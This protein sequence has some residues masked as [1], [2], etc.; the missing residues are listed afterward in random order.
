MNLEEKII[1]HLSGEATPTESMEVEIWKK[2]HPQEY[3]HWE[4][5]Y[6]LDLY[7][8]IQFT[9]KKPVII[10]Y[11][12]LMYGSIAAVFL[13]LM[14]TAWFLRQNINPKPSVIEIENRNQYSKVISLPDG[15]KI[16]LSKNAGIKYAINFNREINVNGTVIL[17]ISK[18]KKHPFK[19][20]TPVSEITVLGTQFMIQQLN[21]GQN[22]LLKEGLVEVRY[23]Q[24]SQKSTLHENGDMLSIDG[25]GNFKSL[26][27]VNCNLYMSWTKSKIN[28]NQCS[29]K[30]VLAYL[31][32][33][34]NLTIRVQDNNILDTKLVGSAPTHPPDL[35][36][37]AIS[38]ITKKKLIK[39]NKTYILQ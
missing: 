21:N 16:T 10:S 11:K 12:K 38:Q 24:N 7:D 2:S 18:D 35:M 39:E 26:Q 36:L 5:A 19:V 15:S 20:H 31:E 1:Q 28:F 37:E 25:E 8:N 29:V 27:K 23:N 34:Y 32:T 9:R 22:I 3:E 4:K 17:H 30:E 13:V 6:H 14:S 33:T